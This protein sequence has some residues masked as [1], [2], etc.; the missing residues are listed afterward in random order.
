MDESRR[1]FLKIA[2]CSAVGAAWGVPVIRAIGKALQAE[3]A[4]GA[5]TGKRWALAID[6]QKCMNPEVVRACQQVCHRIHNVPEIDNPEEE[7]K[8]IWDEKFDNAFP[9]KVHE[10]TTDSL[11]G[12]PVMVLCNHC[13]RP[14]CVRVCPTQATW[15]REDGVVM[16]DMHRCIGCRYCIVACPF[17]ARSFNW[18][19]P[20]PHIKPDIDPEFPTR[21]KGV[22]EKCNLCAERLAKGLDPACVDAANRVA[23]GGAMYFGDVDDPN[24][25]IVQVLRSRISL[26]RRPHL[27]TQPNVF[28]LV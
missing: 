21:T 15:K 9:D 24:S 10:F 8:W 20:R 5:L 12:K 7:I 26:Q 13:E 28:Y 19:D 18:S 23:G 16:M 25:E 4:P 14:S 22:V 2:G 3:P 17:G 27:G 11:K 1:N 6:I